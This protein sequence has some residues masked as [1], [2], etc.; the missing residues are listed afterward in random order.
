MDSSLPGLE[1]Y[2]KKNPW[3]L[4]ADHR[5]AFRELGLS[6]GLRAVEKLRGLIEENPG[7][8]EGKL[9]LLS[10]IESLM[11]YKP[12]SEAI[13]MFW[14]ENANR[15]ASSWIE[16]R[17]INMVMLATSLAPEGYLAL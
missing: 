12:L 14:L 15:E 5:L 17:D 8:F 11:Q 3:K 16:H 2:A 13:E 4:P 1:F 9:P 7:L 6:I 10:R